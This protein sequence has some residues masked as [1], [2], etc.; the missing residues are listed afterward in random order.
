MKAGQKVKFIVKNAGQTKHEMVVG[1][2]KEL[3]EH[4]V[5]MR[6]MPQM[7]HAGRPQHVDPGKSGELVWQFTR[8]R[9]FEFACLVPGHSEAGMTGTVRV[10]AP[11][12]AAK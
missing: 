8:A 10:A 1:T 3:K 12:A 6:R 7:E 2:G 5:M 11:K 4:A 9:T